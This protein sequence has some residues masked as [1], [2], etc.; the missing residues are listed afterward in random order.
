MRTKT[1]GRFSY[2]KL[3]AREEEETMM[4]GGGPH[5]ENSTATHFHRNNSTQTATGW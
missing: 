4:E 5:T 2:D 1:R 3:Q